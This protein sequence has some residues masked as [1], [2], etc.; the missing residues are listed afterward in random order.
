MSV[1]IISDAEQSSSLVRDVERG[2]VKW[3][4]SFL[5]GC[6]PSA[7]GGGLYAKSDDFETELYSEKYGTNDRAL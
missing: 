1:L 7:R 4:S 2:R 6:S 5:R 3:S